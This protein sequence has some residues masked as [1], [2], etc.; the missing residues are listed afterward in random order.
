MRNGIFAKLFLSFLLII[1]LSFGLSSLLSANFFKT[2]LKMFISDRSEMMQNRIV[3]QL[4]FGYSKGWDRDTIIETLKWGVGVPDRSY[5]F[6]DASGKL[7]YTV[8]NQGVPIVVDQR[9]IEQALSGKGVKDQLEAEDRPVLFTA[10]AIEGADTMMEK[11]VV[12]FSFEFQRDVK[13]FTGPFM[14]SMLITIPIAVAIYYVLGRRL[15]RP[16][17]E[18]AGTALSYAKG[19]F[20]QKVEVR[21]KDEIGQLGATLNYMAN[22]LE[23]L[24]NTRREFL[25]NVSHD[26]RA[27][28]TSINGFLTAIMDGTVPPEREKH[29]LAMMRE[30]SDQMMR[31]VGDLL[32]MARIEAGQFRLEQVNFDL[33]EQIRKTIARMEPLFAQRDITVTLVCSSEGE[34]LDVVADPDRLDQVLAN[35]LQNAVMYS[36]AGSEVQV[37]VSR[38]IAGTV[39]IV[40]DQGIGMSEEEL[41]RI[42][43]RFYKGDKARSR[44]LGT[45]IGLS[46][47]KHI[48]DL[49]GAEITVESE[50]GK[51]TAFTIVLLPS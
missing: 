12:S 51:G 3:Q 16:L 7:L 45:G 35:L 39:I 49:H 20:S 29:Y 32:E 37:T 36:P 44:K 1:M 10:R 48:V 11:V 13:R 43:D 26:L 28:L 25:A 30:S 40:R 47:V 2:N 18:M 21:T 17:K 41:E 34:R 23:T 22:E 19:D 27:P 15:S 31:L 14:T 6:Y 9:L 46:I 33:S 8:G 42:W 4:K 50:P 38:E 5:Q 24:E